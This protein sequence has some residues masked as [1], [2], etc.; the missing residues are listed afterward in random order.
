MKK[1]LA[2][3]LVLGMASIASGL[4][5]TLQISVNGA[6][7]PV[8]SEIIIVE[9]PSGIVTLDIWTTADISAGNNEGYFALA[10]DTTMGTISGGV[11]Q[12]PTEPGI[13]FYDDAVGNGV[14]LPA[15][16]NGIFGSISTTGVVLVFPAG[17]R[18]IDGIQFHCEGEGDA[19]VHLYE[20]SGETTLLDTVIIHQI[21]EPASMLLLGL[22]GL[23]LRRRR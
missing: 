21:P 14:P 16:E 12:F 6:N 22:A 2:F 20:V 9:V 23:L 1:L 3:V 5:S 7:E 10:C 4:A 18:L 8:D 11:S 19:I 15:G 13:W 17:S